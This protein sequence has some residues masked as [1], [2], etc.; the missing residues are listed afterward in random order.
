M[1]IRRS[2]HE[3]SVWCAVE[4]AESGRE[5]VVLL[6]GRLQDAQ[7]SPESLDRLRYS[8]PIAHVAECQQERLSAL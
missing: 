3:Q 4:A 2:V 8:H 1:T 6:Q 5:R 7:V